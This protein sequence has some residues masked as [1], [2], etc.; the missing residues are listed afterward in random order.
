MVSQKEKKSSV[1]PQVTHTILCYLID[2]NQSRQTFTGFW[3]YLTCKLFVSY[4]FCSAFFIFLKH[5][6]LCFIYSKSYLFL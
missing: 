2:Q 6:V 4:S 1:H 3:V 5:L